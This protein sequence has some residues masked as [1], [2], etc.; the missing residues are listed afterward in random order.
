MNSYRIAL[1]P[2]V[3]MLSDDHPDWSQEQL[4][5]H[6]VKV[7][8]GIS[9]FDRASRRSNRKFRKACFLLGLGPDRPYWGNSKKYFG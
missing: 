7:R 9:S 6:A 4:E 5:S 1:R 3:E 8:R 2:L